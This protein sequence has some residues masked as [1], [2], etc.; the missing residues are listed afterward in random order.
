GFLGGVFGGL[1]NILTT[2]GQISG[3]TNT[4]GIG[5]LLGQQ[6]ATLQQ[7]GAGLTSQLASGFGVNLQGLS[8][9]ALVQALSATNFDAIESGL[10]VEDR[11]Q[12]RLLI[13][14]IIENTSG[15]LSNTQAVSQLTRP[16]AQSWSTTAWQWF[17]NAI[18]D[19]AGGLL[20]QYQNP[21]LGIQTAMP[22]TY[23]PTAATTNY[24]GTSSRPTS[25]SAG[26]GDV[27]APSFTNVEKTVD[28]NAEEASNLLFFRYNNRPRS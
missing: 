23:A 25:S 20:P 16:N 6:G 9:A 18:F 11:D 27:F 5:A 1:Q 12:F 8:P 26:G 28:L 3:T 10:S 19:G 2:L 4:A 21:A 14:A 7:T 13:N 17:R 24:V 22:G 15:Q